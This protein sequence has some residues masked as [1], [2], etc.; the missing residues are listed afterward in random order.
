M[1]YM[2][3]RIYHQLVNEFDQDTK[4]FLIGNQGEPVHL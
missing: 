3:N 4:Q 2:N 1:S